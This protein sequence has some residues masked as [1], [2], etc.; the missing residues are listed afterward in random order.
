MIILPFK[1]KPYKVGENLYKQMTLAL[2][3]DQDRQNLLAGLRHS[4]LV[5]D[6]SGKHR[7]Y[8]DEE[9]REYHS[10]TSI[11]RHTAPAEQKAALMKWAKRPGS[12]EQRDLACSIGTAVHSYCEKI[13]KRA[14]I[15]AINSANKRNGWKIYEDGLARP[16]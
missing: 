8:R 7:V 10:V 11:L 14:S 2:P 12:I 3:Q 6:D 15:L 9:E 5:R 1:R 4:S 13:L 16:S